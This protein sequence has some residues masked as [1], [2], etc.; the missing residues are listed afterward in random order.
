MELVFEKRIFLHDHFRLSHQIKTETAL[1][2]KGFDG[3]DDCFIQFMFSSI[4]FY[5]I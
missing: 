1:Q 5:L 3:R 4:L 2:I